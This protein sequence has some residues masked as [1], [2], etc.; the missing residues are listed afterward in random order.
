MKK[1]KRKDMYRLRLSKHAI[2]RL[3][4][5]LENNIRVKF[6]PIRKKK[7]VSKYRQIVFH[8]DDNKL[9]F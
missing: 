2:R 9:P 6:K 4:Y 8:K 1:N 5:K 7:N 3:L